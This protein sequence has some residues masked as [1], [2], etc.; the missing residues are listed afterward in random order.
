M[1]SPSLSMDRDGRGLPWLTGLA[2]AAAAGLWLLLGPVP[3]AL[4]FDRA[5]IA[6]GEIWR[7]VTG[8]LVHSDGRHALWDIGALALI[9]CLMEEKGPRRLAL[10]A[11]A[12]ILAVDAGLWWGLPGLERYCGL[13]GMLNALFVVALA[14]LWRRHRHPVFPLAALI[15]GAKLLAEAVAGQSLVLDTEWPAVP[16]A[17]VAGCL[18]GLA[19]LALEGGLFYD[20]PSKKERP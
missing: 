14:D 3:E 12:G 17:H 2:A 5:A 19:F 4:V 13:S 15:L 16:L 1:S 6:G 8:H 10:A 11:G 7:L 9:G 18:G 20:H